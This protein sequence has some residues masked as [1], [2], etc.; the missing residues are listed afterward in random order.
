MEKNNRTPSDPQDSEEQGHGLLNIL[1]MLIF[2]AIL[3][4]AWFLLDR[5]IN[6]K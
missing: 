5:L 6:G 2:V 3:V 1:K 4:G